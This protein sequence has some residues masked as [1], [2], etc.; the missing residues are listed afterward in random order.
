MERE[1]ATTLEPFRVRVDKAR[2]AEF[3]RETDNA[4]E[5]AAIP[6]AYPAVWLS[7]P[8]VYAAIA[9]ACAQAESL[10]VH[11][12]QSFAYDR[13][14]QFDADYDLG[15]SM[16]REQSPPRLRIRAALTS[17]DGAPVGSFE[18]LLRL[19]PRRDAAS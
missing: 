19:V 13:P 5:L 18:T 14:V 16:A 7:E 2:A 11:E 12:S 17:P 6:L 8:Q 10:P 1:S 3:A 9:R 4:G 15:V